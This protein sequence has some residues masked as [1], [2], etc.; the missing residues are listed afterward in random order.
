MWRKTERGALLKGN[1][2]TDL[3]SEM[4]LLVAITNFKRNLSLSESD[5]LEFPLKIRYL[6]GGSGWGSVS[7][8]IKSGE[9]AIKIREEGEVKF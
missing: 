8:K 6:G 4:A 9:G 3:G 2:P 1:A 7:G 5:G